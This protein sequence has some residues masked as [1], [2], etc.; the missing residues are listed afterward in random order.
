MSFPL[1]SNSRIS[2]VV[3]KF[4]TKMPHAIIIEGEYG[5]GKKT[6]AKYL[7]KMAVCSGEGKPCDSCR[8][9]HLSDVGS[10]PDIEVV[11]VKDDKKTITVDQ[12]RELKNT[13]YLS[14]HTADCRVFIIEKADTMN[15]NA[16]NSLLKVLEEPPAKTYFI[17]LTESKS[18]L[19]ETIQS[20]C[21]LL[22]LFTPDKEEALKY[23]KDSSKFDEKDIINALELNKN[24]I[25]KALEFLNGAKLSKGVTVA[26]R[27]F[28]LIQ[29][30]IVLEALKTTVS[31]ESNRLATNDFVKELKEILAKKI[32]ENLSFK[33]SQKEYM[34]MYDVVCDMEPLLVTNINLTLFFT[35]LTSR[36]MSIKN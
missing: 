27:Y 2:Q 22:S 26:E 32:K 24:N 28:S 7:A 14:S 20:R 12:I 10:H 4:E 35:S 17:L 6:L 5:T 21:T 33:E 1:V 29:Q 13:V 16:S 8:D 15:L 34:T 30:N 9:C 19:L 36:L 23:I 31:L 3:S 11:S 25:G 18:S